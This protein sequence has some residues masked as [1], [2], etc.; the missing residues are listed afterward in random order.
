MKA[1]IAFKRGVWVV[2]G[3]KDG[4][5][6]SKRFGDDKAAALL[7]A[8]DLLSEPEGECRLCGSR[9]QGVVN[10]DDDLSDVFDCYETCASFAERLC[11]NHMWQM[12]NRARRGKPSSFKVSAEIMTAA[13]ARTLKGFADYR[14]QG[15]PVTRCEVRDEDG[16]E[17][18][19]RSASFRLHG[20]AVCKDHARY[21]RDDPDCY[22]YQDGAPERVSKNMDKALEVLLG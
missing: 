19:W 16:E 12:V 13:L 22:R 4:K 9:A 15:R 20:H 11:H 18:C 7:Y 21:M 5:T 6:L 2:S 14:R 10:L 17:R 1:T 8:K 3:M